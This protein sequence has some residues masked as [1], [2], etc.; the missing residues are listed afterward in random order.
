MDLGMTFKY[1]I[2]YPSNFTKIKNNAGK[3]PE[4]YKFWIL[5]FFYLKNNFT[6]PAFECSV[7]IEGKPTWCRELW[8]TYFPSFTWVLPAKFLDTFLED[9]L[10]RSI[11]LI[12]I[13]RTYLQKNQKERLLCLQPLRSYR[14]GVRYLVKKFEVAILLQG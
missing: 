8:W 1:N 13:S 12:K 2:L 6:V 7:L 5:C 3:K 9:Q 11:S 14:Q 4:Q 10:F